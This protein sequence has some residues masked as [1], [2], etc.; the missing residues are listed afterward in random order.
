MKNILPAMQKPCVLHKNVTI[1]IIKAKN[2]S[3]AHQFFL[4]F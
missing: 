3:Y 1:L 4:E 2:D